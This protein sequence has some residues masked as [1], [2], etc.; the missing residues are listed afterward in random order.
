MEG[1]REEDTIINQ[2]RKGEREKSTQVT[3]PIQQSPVH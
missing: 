2:E 1:G 3:Y